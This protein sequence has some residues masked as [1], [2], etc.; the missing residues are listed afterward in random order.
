MRK[1]HIIIG[2]TIFL[3]LTAFLCSAQDRN[4]FRSKTSQ[5]TLLVDAVQDLNDGQ[6]ARAKARLTAIIEY[7]P[8]NDAAQYYAGLCDIYLKNFEDA[9]KELSRAVALD[10]ANYWYKDRLALL[11]S[12]TG[13]VEKTTEIYEALVKSHPKKT[14][15]YYNLVNL[16]AQQNR[17]D[18]MLSTLDEIE[19]MVGKDESTTIA[20]YDIL[21]HKDKAEEAFDVLAAYN[22]EFASPAILTR[23]GDAKLTASEDSLA[24]VYYDE[25]LVESP[26]YAPALLGKSDA[27]RLRRSYDDYFRV[28]RQFAGSPNIPSAMKSQYLSAITDRLDGRFAITYQVQLDSLYDTGVSAHP[29]DSSMLTTAAAYYYRSDR[30]DKALELFKKNSELYPDA[31]APVATYVQALSLCEEWEQLRDACDVA[32]AAF[33]EESAFLGMKSMADYNLQDFHAV[34]KDNLQMMEAFPKDSAIVLQA[35]SSMGDMYHTLGDTK[36]A[37]KMYNKALKLN[38][39]YA[40]VLNNYAYYLSLQERK[41]KK[42]YAMSKITVEQEP[43]NSTYLDTFAWILHQQGKDLEAKSFFKHAMLYGGKDSAVMLDHYAEV[44]FALKEYDLAF[45]NWEQAQ[46]K[47]LDNEIPG[48]DA[49]VAARAKSIGR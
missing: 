13:N 49:K 22:E 24:L 42:A 27:Y 33:P 10:T 1:N 20:R 8:T 40:P 18:E 26:D 36:Q 16:Y 35:L 4:S 44:L 43:D 31:F 7:D 34:I 29:A 38:P 47:N 25:A 3:S 15:L 19:S 2:L 23:M 6:Y 12:M 39:T 9:E 17:L 41:L 46:K 32:F 11:Y 30:R 21:I 28:L 14:E 37:F 45:K 48:L 5:E